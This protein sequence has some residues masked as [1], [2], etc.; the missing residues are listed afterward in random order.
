MADAILVAAAQY[1]RDRRL[2]L[3]PDRI[4][5]LGP[6]PSDLA[7]IDGICVDCQCWIAIA[8]WLETD[9]F[10]GFYGGAEP[11]SDAAPYIRWPE[12]EA[13]ARKAL[14]Q[15]ERKLAGEGWFDGCEPT[16][17]SERRWKLV[18]IHRKLQLRHEM[19]DS[20]NAELKKPKLEAAA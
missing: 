12:L 1:E 15:V 8:E 10:T 11:D 19:V 6:A 20:I 13:A 9:R 16:A 3:A 7:A 17:T 5:K 18:H 2:E 14:H 4:A